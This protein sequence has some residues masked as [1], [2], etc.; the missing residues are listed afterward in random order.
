MG[1]GKISNLLQKSRVLTSSNFSLAMVDF[2][3]GPDKGPDNVA[4][5]VVNLLKGLGDTEEAAKT[6]AVHLGDGLPPIPAKIVTRT[7]TMI[8]KG[9]FEVQRD[10]VC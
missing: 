9:E 3:K 6:P 4:I 1:F 7:R 10:G 2:L 8:L 5:L